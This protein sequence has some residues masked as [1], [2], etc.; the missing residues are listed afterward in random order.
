[1]KRI[2]LGLLFLAYSAGC[3]TQA[4]LAGIA[5]KAKIPQECRFMGTTPQVADLGTQKNLEKIVAAMGGGNVIIV[6][7]RHMNPGLLALANTWWGDLYDC[8]N[9]NQ[10][11]GTDIRVLSAALAHPVDSRVKEASLNVRISS[12][13]EAVRGCQFLANVNDLTSGEVTHGTY[14]VRQAVLRYNTVS[15]GGDTVL[16]TSDPHTGEAY[17]CSAQPAEIQRP[18]SAPVAA[19]SPV[20][21]ESPTVSTTPQGLKRPQLVRGEAEAWKVLVTDN[22]RPLEGCRSVGS[23]GRE[24][25]V[26]HPDMLIELRGEAARSG[27]NVVF[28]PAAG[29][30][31]RGEIFS[32]PSARDSF[33][34]APAEAVPREESLPVVP[35]APVTP[36]VPRSEPTMLRVESPPSVTPEPS[37]PA[38]S[39]QSPTQPIQK[40]ESKPILRIE[41]VADAKD[42][43][44]VLVTDDVQAVLGCRSLK[45]TSKEYD[46]AGSFPVRDVQEDAARIGGNVVLT[47]TKGGRQPGLIFSCP[48]TK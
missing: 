41:V 26:S 18:I 24:Y 1:M 15:A 22:R 30:S 40:P 17:R 37:A 9:P 25:D 20:S 19:E 32:C 13:P 33:P 44:K 28:I 4:Q 42:A 7:G 21:R 45:S 3:A 38:K 11:Q 12:N 29:R 36:P 48:S 16:L 6:T 5:A 46:F 2:L 14:P 39:A 34:D 35:E 31:Y 8:D 10:Y 43:W 47:P 27:G 23:T